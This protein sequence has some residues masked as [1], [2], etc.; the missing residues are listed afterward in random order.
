MSTYLSIVS[1]KPSDDLTM[2]HLTSGSTVSEIV[3]SP[4]PSMAYQTVTSTSNL[5]PLVTGY[6]SFYTSGSIVSEIVG[7]SGPYQNTTTSSSSTQY[8]TLT[9]T[10]IAPAN[11]T[12]Y[13]SF[14]TSGSSVLEVIGEAPATQY[15]TLQQKHGVQERL[16]IQV[17]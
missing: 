11:Q 12:P 9:L 17:L 5:K 7:N 4:V 15:Q 2:N 1:S 3:G 6:T 8:V 10:N 16:A 14:I 13:T